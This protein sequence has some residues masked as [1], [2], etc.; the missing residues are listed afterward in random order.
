[1]GIRIG[2]AAGAFDLFHIGHLNILQ[3]AKEHCDYL[4]AGVVS[5]ELCERNK[6]KRPVIPLNERLEIVGNVKCVDRAVAEVLPDKLDTWYEVG[7]NV[8]FKGDDWRNT[9]QGD[10]LERRFGSVGVD[11]VY[12]PYTTQTSSTLLREALVVTTGR[13][14][15]A[16]LAGPIQDQ[17]ASSAAL[18]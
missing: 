1:M 4:I 14:A 17:A 12:F 5:D 13:A 2:Y 9:P 15:S 16:G 6:G 7:F 10:E 8:F 3:R 11:V 18:P